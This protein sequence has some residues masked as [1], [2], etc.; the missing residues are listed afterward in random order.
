[1]AWYP[2]VLSAWAPRP[3]RAAPVWAGLMNG[4]GGP[5]LLRIRV[6]G[7]ARRWLSTA[8]SSLT[9]SR[10][11]QA[12]RTKLK[13]P[14]QRGSRGARDGFGSGQASAFSQV[15]SVEL[16]K[17]APITWQH[18]RSRE[19]YEG[20]VEGLGCFGGA[21]VHTRTMRAREV[22]AAKAKGIS[23]RH[24]AGL[25]GAQRAAPLLEFGPY[26]TGLGHGRARGFFNPNPKICSQKI[27]LGDFL[28]YLS[29]VGQ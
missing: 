17:H 26:R 1:M 27:E 11:G 19:D 8:T 28:H 25:E 29:G 6:H 5:T 18:N 22:P 13:S 2:T 9:P 24:R 4:S 16:A 10:G 12:S 20:Q 23:R 14:V 21:V 15:A 3:L 7:T